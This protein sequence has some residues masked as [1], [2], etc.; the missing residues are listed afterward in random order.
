M[1]VPLAAVIF[2]VDGVLVQSM[3]RNAEAYRRTF[4]PLGVRIEPQEV[5]ANEGRG[6]RVLIAKLARDHGM[7][8]SAAQLDEMTRRHH[9]LLASLGPMPLYPGVDALLRSL[10]RRGLRLAIVPGNWRAIALAPVGDAAPASH[11][12]A[13]QGWTPA[14]PAVAA[15]AELVIDAKRLGLD[16]GSATVL[17][18][19][20]FGIPLYGTMAHSY[21]QAHE[22]EGDAFLDFARAHPD[23]STLLIDTYDTEAGARKVVEL[24]PRLR[25]EGIDVNAVRLDSGDLAAHARKVRAILDAGGCSAIRIFVSGGLDEFDLERMASAPIDG[26][27]VGTALVTSSDAPGLDCAYKLQEYAGIA[28]RKRSEG[29]ATWPGRKQVFRSP[30]GDLLALAEE[31][32]PGTPLLAPAMRAGRRLAR[33]QTLA[34]L[35]ARAL[36]GYEQLPPALRSLRKAEPGYRVEVSDALRALA[37]EVDRRGT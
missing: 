8:L 28:R 12:I 4:E 3:E 13:G 9:E 21:V 23:N 19:K 1:V 11:P 20:R 24:V 30:Q 25:S 14:L 2:D 22:R 17:A 26:F 36:A 10:H 15:L 37:A 32:H 31:R 27:G 6:S 5:F 16:P 34:A 33:P 29:K 18:G 35:R 7:A